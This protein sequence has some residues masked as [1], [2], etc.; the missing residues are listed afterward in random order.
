MK[1]LYDTVIHTVLMNSSLTDSWNIA[2]WHI[3]PSTSCNICNDK[4]FYYNCTKN[5]NQHKI[6]HNQYIRY[7]VNRLQKAAD[8]SSTSFSGNY[9]VNNCF[10]LTCGRQSINVE[11]ESVSVEGEVKQ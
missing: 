6:M 8:Y 7:L 4:H 5:Y 11:S 10:L 3:L 2:N 9:S 1:C